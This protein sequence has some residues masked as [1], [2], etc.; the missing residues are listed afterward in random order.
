MA[1]SPYGDIIQIAIKIMTTIGVFVCA[2][3]LYQLIS[4]FSLYYGSP[5]YPRYLHGTKPYALITG[6]TDGIGKA[7]A[8]ELIKKGFNLIVH[9]RSEEKLLKVVKGLRELGKGKDVTYF[10]A[11]AGDAG[12]DF[13]KI[14]EEFKDLNITLFINNVAGGSLRPETIDNYTEDEL[15]LDIHINALFAMN[16]TRAFLPNLRSTATTSGP[17]HVVFV[18][19]VG[20]K[21]PIPRLSTYTS[22]KAFLR[23]LTRSLN[24]D[25]RYKPSTTTSSGTGTRLTFSYLEVGTVVTNSNRTTTGVFTPDAKAFAK[26]FVETV[27][28]GR[29][30]Y[31]PYM[32]HGMQ[33]W[34]VRLLPESA[35]EKSSGETMEGIF[36]QK[37]D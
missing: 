16:L 24:V 13:E 18:G 26:S 19:S 1:P 29:E 2:K 36:A 30:V 31:Y 20:H 14:V 12:V 4:F 8:E 23:Q 7:V 22:S 10:L 35:V 9:G 11:S 6:A 28:C 21:L 27:G 25:E 17:T 34:F 15:L 37:R 3:S 33:G 5:Y 32:R